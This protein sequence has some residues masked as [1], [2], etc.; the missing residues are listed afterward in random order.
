[1]ALAGSLADLSD[2]KLI[3]DLPEEDPTDDRF[4]ERMLVTASQL[5]EAWCGRTFGYAASLSE[6]HDGGAPFLYVQRPPIDPSVTVTVSIDPDGVNETMVLSDFYVDLTLGRL[7]PLRNALTGWPY[8]SY[9]SGERRS[10]ID[11]MVRFPRAVLQVGYGGGYK[12]IPDPVTMAVCIAVNGW[13]YAR[14][15][16]PEAE[17]ASMGGGNSRTK[18]QGMGSLPDEALRLLEPYKI[19]HM[20]Y[21]GAGR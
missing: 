12:N 9:V 5:A 11:R 15:S 8:G 19:A 13:W 3:F 6:R 16:D 18:R 14:R 10:Q 17:T 4:I 21:V 20:A 2:F 1:V 7:L